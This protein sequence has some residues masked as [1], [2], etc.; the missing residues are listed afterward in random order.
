MMQRMQTLTRLRLG[1]RVNRLAEEV[2]AWEELDSIP[3]ALSVISGS[4]LEL[5]QALRLSSTHRAL[6]T[7]TDVRVYDRLQLP[8]SGETWS[9]DYIIPGRPYSQ[10]F[11]TR[12]DEVPKEV[13]E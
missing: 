11:L 13:A 4:S 6:T 10:L 1:V 9:V 12:T 7:A 3:A 8:G 5:N 2:R